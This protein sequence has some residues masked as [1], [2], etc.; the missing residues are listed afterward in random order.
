MTFWEMTSC[1]KV[2]SGGGRL[3]KKRPQVLG[4]RAFARSLIL[5]GTVRKSPPA[6]ALYGFSNEIPINCVNFL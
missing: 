2:S 4:A 3:R 6:V 1:F 5:L